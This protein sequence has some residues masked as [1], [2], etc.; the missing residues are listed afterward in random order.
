MS[1]IERLKNKLARLS[2]NTDAMDATGREIQA[3]DGKGLLRAVLQEIDETIL[4][5]EIIFRN[6]AGSTLGF[7][8][9][10]RRL[11][12]VSD[13]P[14]K[15]IPA[16][17]ATALKLPFADA[18]SPAIDALAKLLQ[19]FLKDRDSLTVSFARLSR[20]SDASEIGCSAA[21]L[22]EA[23]SLDLYATSEASQKRLLEKF[24][25]SCADLVQAWLLIDGLDILRSGG[26][27]DQVQQLTELSRGDIAAFDEQLVHASPAAERAHCMLLGTKEPK[28]AT[29]LYAKNAESRA[30]MLLPAEH[31]PEISALW[32]RIN[33]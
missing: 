9:A 3:A 2:A 18:A 17:A 24:I 25:A 12:R 14:A 15:S 26:P 23:W 20:S 30:F 29:I 32:H 22:A 10:N 13:W 8:V 27:A 21:A 28:S 6:A 33:R 31:W 5:R 11:L 4:A 19:V 7:E 16:A 1:D